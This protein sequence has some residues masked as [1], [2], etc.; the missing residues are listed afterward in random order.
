MKTKERRANKKEYKWPSTSNHG[1][2]HHERAGRTMQQ[3]TDTD[4]CSR[5]Q[6][7]EIL[8]RGTVQDSRVMSAKRTTA[9]PQQP[10]HCHMALH[11]VSSAGKV[12]KLRRRRLLLKRLGDEGQGRAEV[13]GGPARPEGAERAPTSTQRQEVQQDCRQG[14]WRG[15]V[16]NRS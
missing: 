12:P 1:G 4:S 3:S 14:T 11:K 13:C 10:H 8:H 16:H 9:C 6:T 5:R 2:R 15:G 7:T